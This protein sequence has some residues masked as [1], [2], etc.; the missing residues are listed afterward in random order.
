MTREKELD[1]HPDSSPVVLE[2]DNKISG[3]IYEISK[4]YP[5][6]GPDEEFRLISLYKKN[7]SSDIRDQLVLHNLLLVVSIASKIWHKKSSNEQMFALS[8]LFQQGIIGLI[9]AIECFD[10]NK[11]FRLSTHATWWIRQSIL[12][13]IGKSTPIRF[14]ES[15]ENQFSR[16]KQAEKSIQEI[17][18]RKPTNKELAGILKMEPYQIE[19]IKNLAA[20]GIVSFDIIKAGDVICGVDE[21][22][23][24]AVVKEQI[25][26]ELNNLLK[27][28]NYQERK[29]IAMIFG[30]NNQDSQNIKEVSEKLDLS[31]RR[32][33]QIQKKALCKLGYFGEKL[34]DFQ[35]LLNEVS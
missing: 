22:V 3:K 33:C 28:L 25:I 26:S 24:A 19:N 1:R 5:P 8:D 6:F 29:V 15:F 14:P 23:E 27:N 32:V 2:K 35:A 16:I 18:E 30:L 12:R 9:K 34:K 11:G 31:R 7:A 20:K 21:S 17:K 10:I 4:K 13:F